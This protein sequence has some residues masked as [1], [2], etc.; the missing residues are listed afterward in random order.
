MNRV[1]IMHLDTST[2]SHWTYYS[3][4][5]NCYSF[6]RGAPGPAAM[7]TKVSEANCLPRVGVGRARSLEGAYPNSYVYVLDDSM[8]TGT[9]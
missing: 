5:T 6:E 9:L 3:T 8:Y 2:S 1:P 4:H 7:S